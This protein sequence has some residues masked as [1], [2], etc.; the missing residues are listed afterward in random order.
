LGDD[1][2]AIG[3]IGGFNLTFL[4]GKLTILALT[5]F[6]PEQ[7][8]RVLSPQGVNAN[9]QWRFYNDV[10]V[11]WK[12]TDTWTFV[13]E[14]NWVRDAYG[15]VGKPVNGF[16]AAQYASYALSDTIALNARA[17]IWRDDNNFFVAS[18]GGNTDFV[19]FQQGLSTQAVNVAP[20]SNTTYGELALGVTWKP[21]LPAPITGLLVRPE[22]R[23]DHSFTDNNPF[24]NNPPFNTKGTANSFT[25]GTDLVVTF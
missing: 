22:I 14:A 15:F 3:G 16:G 2:G 6:G 11:T 19:R 24:N 13:T 18:F 10:V 23:W 7:A 1:N 12:A 25:F 17:E 4:D 5:H 8:T 20:G 21:N 9:G